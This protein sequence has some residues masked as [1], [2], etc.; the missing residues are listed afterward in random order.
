M[1][2]IILIFAGFLTVF[3]LSCQSELDSVPGNFEIAEEDAAKKLPHAP[4]GIVYVETYNQSVKIDFSLSEALAYYLTYRC[5]STHQFDNGEYRCGKALDTIQTIGKLVAVYEVQSTSFQWVFSSRSCPLCLDNNIILSKLHYALAQACFQDDIS[6]QTRKA[7]L[8]LA[9]D[10]QKKILEGQLEYDNFKAVNSNMFL[11]AVIMAKEENA[12]FIA[13]VQ[14]NAE[15][16]NVLC[17]S[18]VP[19]LT[20]LKECRILRQFALQFLSN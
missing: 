19:S 3:M 8:K 1:K 7:V 14:E 13:A 11:M 16:Q 10:K 5:D 17:F 4:T 12:D 9:V 2:P 15:L 18:A 20:Y 6:T